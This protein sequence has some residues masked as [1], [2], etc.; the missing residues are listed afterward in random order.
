MDGPAPAVTFSVVTT[1]GGGSLQEKVM[2]KAMG[3][4]MR[5][6]GVRHFHRDV[7]L[8]GAELPVLSH[9]LLPWGWSAVS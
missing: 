5:K 3:K 9:P 4:N 2:T 7:G 6:S 8:G 1:M